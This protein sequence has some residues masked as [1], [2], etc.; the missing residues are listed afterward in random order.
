MNKNNSFSNALKWAYTGNWGDR[1]LSA[2]FIFILAGILGP[3]D[4]GVA[5][6][7][8]TYVAFLQMFLDQGVAA[9]LIQR[10]DLEQEHLD[11]VFWMDVVL[12]CLLVLVSLLFASWW[13]GRNHAPEAAKLIPVLSFTIV[14]EALSIVQTA[15]LKRDLDFKSLAIRTN[16]S[17]LI[18]G[19]FGVVMALAGYGVWALVGQQIVKDLSAVILLWNLST[20]RPRFEFSWKHLRELMGF[21]VPNFL[22][23]IAI[24]ADIQA[25]SIILGLLFGPLAVGLYRLADRV[26]NSVIVVATS[27]IQSV[28]FPEFS[29]L[30]DKA[31]ELRNSVLTCVRLSSAATLPALAGLIAVGSPL[32]A[33]LGTKWIPA[34]GV[35]KILSLAGMAVIFIYFTGPLL[36]ALAKTREVAILEWGRT[37]IGLAILVGA[38]ILVR[39]G[40]VPTQIMTIALSRLVMSTLV[41]MPVFLF[42]LMRLTQVSLKDLARCVAPATAS[43]ASVVG[44]VRLLEIS[45][46][47][48]HA[49][50]ALALAVYTVVGGSSG[51]AV[52]LGLDTQLKKAVLALLRSKSGSDTMVDEL[53]LAKELLNVPLPQYSVPREKALEAPLVSII[54]RAYNRAYILA[55]AIESALGQ[56]YQNFEIVVVDDASTDNTAALVQ[57]FPGNRIKYVRHEKNMG[58]GAACN[59]G[60]NSSD[61]DLIAFLDSDDLWKFD[62]LE[63]QVRFLAQHPE[64]DV[65]FG[66]VEM[67]EGDITSPSLIALMQHFPKLLPKE[68]RAKEHVISGRDMYLCLLEEVPIK[69]TAMVLRK[70]VFDRVGKFNEDCR[71]GEDWEFL[72]RLAP[73]ACFG[74]IDERVAVQRRTPDAT[75]RLYWEDDKAFLLSRFRRE[76]AAV[77]HD[78]QAV[79]AANRG[80]TSHCINLGGFYMDSGRW[81][82]SLS[83]YLQGF[84]ETGHPIML[85]RAASTFLPFRLNSLMK[86]AFRTLR[87]RKRAISESV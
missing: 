86:R 17:A 81:K 69:P 9:A 61:G 11:A 33:T 6:I 67:V 59:T 58:V 43:A 56:T 32:M 4:F 82:E 18:G 16:A 24:F 34:S 10:K 54:I 15:T 23:Q 36:Q 20:W 80:I 47:F 65:V 77:I 30:Q 74:Y 46:L 41:V 21:S 13:A 60:I 42:I 87:P 49:R 62:T 68:P 50:P 83:I 48:S 5:A 64:V 71:S 37:I 75:H 55:E 35:L 52:L 79:R 22:A 25:A 2:I 28:S 31:A 78:R 73:S 27:S 7:A 84:R 38:G 76:K 85:L 72:L 57:R 44:V 39:G 14:I 66:D 3:R 70:E 51:L 8:V 1:A 45:G 26:V 29:R 12:S 63:H 53:S 19:L 40:P